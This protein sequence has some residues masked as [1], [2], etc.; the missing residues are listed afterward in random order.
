MYPLRSL[1]RSPPAAVAELPFDP[2][3]PAVECARLRPMITPPSASS[4]PTGICAGAGVAVVVVLAGMTKYLPIERRT[5]AS[6]APPMPPP[7][8]A[9]GGETVIR[10]LGIG[11]CFLYYA[12]Q[13]EGKKGK[14]EISSRTRGTQASEKGKREKGRGR[15]G[16]GGEDRGRMESSFGAGGERNSGKGRAEVRTHLLKFGLTVPL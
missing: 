14:R 5:A 1:H 2:V 15:V 13:Q 7:S 3:A 4:S 11:D 16:G 10:W 8:S 9:P 12:S 6:A